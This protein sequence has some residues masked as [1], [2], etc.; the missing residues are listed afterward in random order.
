VDGYVRLERETRTATRV[1]DHT[2]AWSALEPVASV[3]GT[4]QARIERFCAEK[5]ITVAALTALGTR[6]RNGNGG[7]VELAWGYPARVNGRHV[8]TAVKFRPLGTDKPRYALTPSTFLAPIIAGNRASLDWFLAEGET[9]AARIYGLVGDAA[10]VLVLPA[11]AQAFKP[12]WAAAI[13]RGATVHLCHDADAAG[14]QGADKAAR[15]LGGRTVRVRPPVD[16]TDWCD[17]PGSRD[18]FVRIVSEARAAQVRDREYAFTPLAGFLEHP[19]PNAEPLLGEAG[20]IY[21]AAGSLLLVYGAEGSGKSTWTVDAVAHLAAGIPWLGIPVPRPV[22]FVVIENEGPPGLFQAKLAAKA[23]SWDGPAWTD[24]VTVYA[25]PW[26]GFSV[27]D[28][29]ARAALAAHCDEHT[30]DV[31]VAN[32]TLGLGVAGSGRPDET[33]QFMDWLVQCG[34]KSTRAF[35]LLHHE[36]KAG[37]ISGD[38]GRHPDTKVQLQLDGNRPRT[39]LVWEKTRWASLPADGHPKAVMLDWVPA[40]QGYTVVE[41]DTVGAT[42][43]ELRARIDAFLAEHPWSST[44]AIETHVKGTNA[45]KRELLNSGHYDEVRGPRGAKLWNIWRDPAEGSADGVAG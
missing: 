23:S 36:N 2:A 16:G 8:V 30:I 35:W 17:W 18:E 28:P 31:V 13:P 42:D 7:A 43:D 39:K 3:N 32:P 24:N 9:D 29:D 4:T 5:R 41:L 11:G 22:R 19:Y 12:E 34:L 20:T 38:W 45:R 25:A 21:L 26:G 14:D 6:V 40:T 10:A 37:Q 33:Q 44:T 1:A 27:A 15:T